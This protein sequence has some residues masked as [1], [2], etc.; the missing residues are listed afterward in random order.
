MELS[1][2][3]ISNEILSRLQVNTQKLLN[4]RGLCSC[5]LHKDN[6]PSFSVD[7]DKG[8]YNCF[9][10]QSHGTLKSLYYQITGHS[11]MKDLG[12]KTD[13]STF[14]IKRDD[15]VISYQETPKT[16]IVFEVFDY[17]ECESSQEAKDYL[18]KRG[19]SLKTA[20]SMKMRYVYSG[21]AKNGANISDKDQWVYFNNRLTI[22][23][24]ENGKL[25]SIE[26]RDVLGEEVFK[27]NLREKGLE[28][29]SYKKVLYPRASSTQTLFQYDNLNKNEPLYFVEGLM[30]LA[31]LREDPYFSN[32]TAVFGASIGNRQQYLL[33]QFKDL[34]YIA[35]HDKAGLISIQ[36]LKNTIGRE[37]YY[38]FSPPGTK[39]VGDIPKLGITVK[40]LR[41]RHWLDNM[42][43]SKSF[44]IVKEA[45]LANLKKE[46]LDI[47]I[48]TYGGK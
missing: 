6:H 11:I 34:V 26:G 42:K 38:M 27:R 30:D 48:Q 44:D 10:C 35:D 40:G 39:D 5:P 41:E 3:E 22:P 18:E 1:T 9:S 19:I 20:K 21:V 31:V 15:P 16:N 4:G 25:L 37:F 29:I 7:I 32:S 17:S 23:I 13:F 14:K 43:S 2:R 36:R 8:I 45:K 12:I 46:D 47:I 24:F 28:E 33:K